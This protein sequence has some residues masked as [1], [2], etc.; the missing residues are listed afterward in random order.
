MDEEQV[1]KKKL[2]EEQALSQAKEQGIRFATY[3]TIRDGETGLMGQEIRYETEEE[4][5]EA[6]GKNAVL[7]E[8]RTQIESNIDEEKEEE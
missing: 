6:G 3:W 4:A 5:R 2:S 8:N 1:I 7:V